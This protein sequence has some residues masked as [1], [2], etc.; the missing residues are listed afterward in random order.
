MNARCVP[1][2]PCGAYDRREL[3]PFHREYSVGKQS[4]ERRSSTM[5]LIIFGPLSLLRWA[6]LFA[7]NSYTVAD[8]SCLMQLT[9]NNAASQAHGRSL[10]LSSMLIPLNRLALL[11]LVPASLL[12]QGI[13][14]T[15]SVHNCVVQFQDFD[16]EY[17][18][19]VVPSY[20][21]CA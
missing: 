17:N 13:L 4:R 15:V 7:R 12:V 21:S 9:K 14:L 11:W 2:C 19:F 18:F 1:F 16:R 10:N 8:G 6:S 3:S 5:P 20:R